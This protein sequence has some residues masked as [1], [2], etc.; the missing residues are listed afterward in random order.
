[1]GG[2]EQAVD[3]EV[4]HEGAV[5]EHLVR[6]AEAEAGEVELDHLALPRP[7]LHP[8]RGDGGW[9]WLLR[10]EW[11]RRRRERFRI[12]RVR[13]CRADVDRA[14]SVVGAGLSPV[15]RPVFVILYKKRHV[16]IELITHVENC[17]I[18]NAWPLASAVC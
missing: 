8:H 4:V 6:L 2:G 16:E 13:A 7:P 15:L 5:D 14:D 9:R 11:R 18:S 17:A 1:M 12:H 10:V 3:E